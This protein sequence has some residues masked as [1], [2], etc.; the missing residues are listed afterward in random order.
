MIRSSGDTRDMYCKKLKDCKKIV[1]GDK[2]ALREL[3]RP[4]RSGIEVR[5]SLAHAVVARGRTTIKHKLK[6]SEV[7]FMLEGKALM[8][9]DDE[10]KRVRPGD[11]I[12]IPPRAVQHI[13]NTGKTALKFLCIVDPAWRAEDEEICL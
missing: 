13:E 8:Y 5:Y 9:I 2:A 3:L 7:Y 6:T 10:K 12:Y 4:G 1:S 11:V